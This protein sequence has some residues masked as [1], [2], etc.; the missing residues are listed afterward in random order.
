MHKEIP[1]KEIKY[2][3]LDLDGTLLDLYFDD[4]FWAHL[5]PEKYAEKHDISFGAAK[6]HLYKTYKSHEKTLNWCDIDFWSRE[7]NLD[8]P[9]LKEQIRHLIEVH[10]HVIEFLEKMRPDHATDIIETMWAGL[11]KPFFIN[12]SNNGSVPN[13]PDDAYMEFLCAAVGVKL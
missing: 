4:Y 6:D 11:D 7:L 10:P 2:V 1:L 8:I 5:V 12:T 13:M 3:L 9:A